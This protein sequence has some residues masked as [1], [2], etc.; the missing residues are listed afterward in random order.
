MAVAL[1]AA[2]WFLLG[3]GIGGLIAYKTHN[4]VAVW[5]GA[6]GFIFAVNGLFG[7]GPAMMFVFGGIVGFPG[8]LLAVWLT[9]LTNRMDAKRDGVVITT[10]G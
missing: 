5:A 8:G 7:Y 6:L 9:R 2:F 4:P 1:V 3:I 10:R